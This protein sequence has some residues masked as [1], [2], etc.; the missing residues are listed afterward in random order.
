VAKDKPAHRTRIRRSSQ[1]GPRWDEW[2]SPD[3]KIASPGENGHAARISELAYF[4]WQERGSP[5]GSS[6]ED[7]FRAEAILSGLAPR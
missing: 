5:H 7:W 2:I 1:T 3:G 4:L 6:E